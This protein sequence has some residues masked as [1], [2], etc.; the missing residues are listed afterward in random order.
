M[1][2]G[3][4]YGGIPPAKERAV[5]SRVGDDD[6]LRIEWPQ[7]I[8][9]GDGNDPG[10]VLRH[11]ETGEECEATNLKALSA[12]IWTASRGGEPIATDDPG[13]SLDGLWA[14]AETPRN[15]EIRA[16]RTAVG[17]LGLRVREVEP[18]VEVIRVTAEDGVIEVEGAVAYG[19]PIRGAAKLVAVARRGPEPVSGPANFQGRWFDGGIEI[20]PM[21]ETQVRRRV[22]WDLYAEFSGTRLPLATRLDDITDKKT[23]IRFPAQRVGQVRVRPYYTETDS[24]AVA[25]SV[26]EESS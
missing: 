7:P 2:I 8:H 19:E 12:G 21:A 17:T 6:T 13:F 5:T 15:R 22:F 25:L 24:L 23:K 16:F 18:Y 26:E 4:R 10:I 9:G 14:Y 20:A 1:S 11:V 3:A